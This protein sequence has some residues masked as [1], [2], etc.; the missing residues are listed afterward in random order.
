MFGL[1][2]GFGGKD[3]FEWKNKVCDIWV[4][5]AQIWVRIICAWS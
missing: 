1:M 2:G 3:E 4:G 5:K